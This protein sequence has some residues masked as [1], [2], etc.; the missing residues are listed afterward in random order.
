MDTNYEKIK[1]SLRAVGREALRVRLIEGISLLGTAFLLLLSVGLVLANQLS[2]IPYART[3]YLILC[4]ATIF[5]VSYRYI[6]TPVLSLRS[7]DRLAL[8]IE[9]HL[10]GL[11]DLLISSLQLGRDLENPQ[12]THL[13]SHEL[14]SSLFGQ[15]AE[16]LQGL[17]LQDVVERRN[18]RRN[19]KA[20]G[21]M[22]AVFAALSVLNP[23]Y[24]V[25]RFHLLLEPQYAP[26]GLIHPGVPAI[27]DIT[28]TY[29]YPAYTGLKPRTVSGTSGDIRTLKGSEVEILALSN[30]AI[31][32]A[33]IL[34]NESTR[35]QMSVETPNS[36]KGSLIVLD[37]GS[38]CFE[39]LPAGGESSQKSKPHKILVEDDDYPEIKILSPTSGKVVGE[40]DVIKLAYEATDDFGLKETRL[41]VGEWPGDK[42]AE[43]GLKVMKEAKK[44][45]RDSI[46][47]DLSELRLL[48]GEK[49]PYYLE[50]V[51]NDAVSGP[52]VARSK[53]QY[54]EVYSTQKRHD[55][56]LSLQDKLLREMIQL[57]AEKLVHPPN[58]TASRDDLLLQQETL[59]DRTI[60]FLVLFDRVL[61]DME[62]DALANY[63][64]Y[65][66]LEN[67]RNRISQL[68]DGKEKKLEKAERY[69]PVL[70]VTFINE[71]QAFQEDETV[72]L[73]NDVMFLV[74][75]L[76]KQRLDD[77]LDQDRQIERTEKTLTDL[78]NDLAQGKT[79]ELED[80]VMKEIQKLEDMIRSM[81]EKLS[82]LSSNWGDEFLNLEALK[83]LGEFTLNKDMQEMKDAL[84]RGDLEAALK[85]ALK[86][87]NALES[88]LAEMEQSAQQYVD[89]TYSH[90]LQEMSSLEK[91]LKELEEDEQQLAQQTEALKK[92][93]QSRTFEEMDLALSGFFERQLER[94]EGIKN[95]LS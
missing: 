24:I 16:R 9:K 84:A 64:V 11:K 27:G 3:G 67:M 5:Y 55:E 71:V 4:I 60:N 89:S 46:N 40:R 63:A 70:P 82:K 65:Y 91:M 58:A 51:D 45:Y 26:S 87:A 49:V 1:E 92:D 7:E 59:I 73:E 23:K 86:A 85:A 72:E 28:L 69:G 90:S 94:Q 78:L 21:A 57:L 22:V 48:P 62:E 14:I 43:K 88:M 37:A 54:L 29:R 39:T 2:L 19:V 74:E 75:L 53:T 33:S 35:V 41:V 13:Y 15:T 81:M 80:K 32:S 34:I 68:N 44:K 93:I 10:P 56:L 18:L 20:L 42:R 31:A 6:L 47:W 77:F 50:A 76:R 52:K 61:T 79:D 83:E 95:N 17:R 38:Y 8:I 12:R 36:I 66:S 25:Q 30:Q